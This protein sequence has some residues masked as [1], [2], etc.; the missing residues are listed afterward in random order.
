MLLFSNERPK[1]VVIQGGK[2][3]KL[4]YAWVDYLNEVLRT[5]PEFLSELVQIRVKCN[6]DIA[7]HPQLQVINLNQMDELLHVESVK[8]AV[9]PQDEAAFEP[10]YAFP[11]VQDMDDMPTPRWVAGVLGLINGF[12]GVSENGMGPI[13]A[14]VDLETKLIV[15]FVVSDPYKKRE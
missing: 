9:L 3:Q 11:N 13:S 15:E 7:M 10:V 6:A 14:I 4:G 12:I 2:A 5:D 1:R 8:S